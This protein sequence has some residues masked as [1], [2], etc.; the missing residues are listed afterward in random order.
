M[1]ITVDTVM[2]WGPCWNYN[3]ARVTELFGGKDNPSVDDLLALPISDSDKL[4]ILLHP[5]IIPNRDLRELACVYAESA[6]HQER[7][8]GREPDPRSWAAIE[9]VRKW[10]QNEISDV[11]LAA[12]EAAA[13]AAA[14]AAWDALVSEQL[15]LA[16]I[17]AKTGAKQ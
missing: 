11:E 8:A 16:V 2:S 7:R 15:K 10:L 1:N 3:R 9:A 4:W 6:L 14:W 12:A 17:A 5:E 13:E